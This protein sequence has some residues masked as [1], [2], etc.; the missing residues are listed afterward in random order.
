AA[1][2]RG[3]M[4]G[5]RRLPEELLFDSANSLRSAAGLVRDLHPGDAGS[6]DVAAQAAG[7]DV[8]L[9]VLT[10]IAPLQELVSR[11]RQNLA[12]VE[13]IARGGR[14]ARSEAVRRI[15]RDLEALAERVRAAIDRP[16]R[17]IVSAATAD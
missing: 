8:L 17:R 14:A 6:D 9:Q 12:A 16:E 5:P 10:A 4:D 15:Q 2:R 7:G 1:E 3:L 11:A 13:A